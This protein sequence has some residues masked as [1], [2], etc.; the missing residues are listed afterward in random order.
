MTQMPAA[1]QISWIFFNEFM[2]KTKS[3]K[4]NEYEDFQAK[5]RSGRIGKLRLIVMSYKL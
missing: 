3:L 5:E 2:S 4:P 1:T